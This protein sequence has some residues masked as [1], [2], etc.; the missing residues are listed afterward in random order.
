MAPTVLPRLSIMM[1]L[2]YALWGAWLPIV[3]RYLKALPAEGGLGFD[4]S[5]IG[6]ILGLAS[7]GAITSPFIAG[8]LADRYFRTERF[9]ACLL[10][11]GGTVIFV[12]SYQTSYVA[13]MLLIT[14]YE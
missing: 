8:Q 7:I 2:Q 11:L 14:L 12:L 10:A 5:Q 6:W 9:L 4:D 1:L 13:W 3:A